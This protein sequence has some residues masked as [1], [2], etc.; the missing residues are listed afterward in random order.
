M[1]YY[2]VAVLKRTY[3]PGVSH[4]EAIRQRQHGARLTVPKHEARRVDRVSA[5]YS[6]EFLYH[7]GDVSYGFS[8]FSLARG[9]GSGYKVSA[10]W[11]GREDSALSQCY[12]FRSRREAIRAAQHRMVQ[13]TAA[14]W[15]STDRAW[16]RAARRREFCD[17]PFT[18]T[19][20]WH[21]TEE[22]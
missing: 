11:P 5:K 6:R 12:V 1:F 14:R 21:N 4:K 15:Y 19:V 17:D 22:W 18:R 9:S 10:Y 2:R 7:F 8:L 20:R 3:G 13:E 16:R